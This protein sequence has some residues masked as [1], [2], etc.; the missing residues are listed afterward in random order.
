[1]FAAQI[2]G[3]SRI[4]MVDVP[5]PALPA[6]AGG[7]PQI[8]FQPELTCLCGS[9]LP[10]FLRAEEQPDPQLGHSLHEMIGTVVA[11]NGGAFGRATACC[12]C[13]TSSWGFSSV[14]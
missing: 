2:T 4:E 12:A 11:T 7:Q 13:R 1:M 14:S 9:D 5:E 8:V 10:F 3:P 6:A